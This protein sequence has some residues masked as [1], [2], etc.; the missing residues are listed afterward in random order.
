MV[1][2]RKDRIS[3]GDA[4]ATSVTVSP[5]QLPVMGGADLAVHP[6]ECV[7]LGGPSGAGKSSLLRG[8]EELG[9]GLGRIVEHLVGEPGL[10]H[11]AGPHHHHPVLQIA[12]NLVTGPRLVLM[13][14]PTSGLD[15][16]V[17]ARLLD[18]I[19]GEELGVGLG[20]IV[21]H[22]VGEPGLDHPAGPHHHH[23]VRLRGGVQLPVMGGA[24]LAVHPGECV[25][26]GGP[27]GAGKSSRRNCDT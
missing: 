15:V 19:R 14:E 12:R 17:Q 13:D 27:S 11:P 7:V 16:S 1:R 8:D 23:P 10:D 4:E 26:L 5:V 20:R 18:L 24:D 9:V 3:R 21:E 6:G 25:V 2:R 22:L